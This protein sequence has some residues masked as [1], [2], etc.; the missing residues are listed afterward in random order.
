M[1]VWLAMLTIAVVLMVLLQILTLRNLNATEWRVMDLAADI[2]EDKRLDA[3]HR[4][5]E[6]MQRED[7]AGDRG[8]LDRAKQ[9]E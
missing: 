3:H 9:V 4:A 7:D 1:R 2:A 5:M 8:W 6:A